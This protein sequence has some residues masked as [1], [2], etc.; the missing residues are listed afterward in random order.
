MKSPIDFLPKNSVFSQMVGIS[1]AIVFV[2]GAYKTVKD[3]L[4][5]NNDRAIKRIE[6]KEQNLEYLDSKINALS[7]RVIN[8]E[9]SNSYL[10]VRINELEN[11]K[12]YRVTPGLINGIREGVLAGIPEER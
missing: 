10:V 2:V 5:D 1:A 9:L 11:G 4:S 12:V 8:L 3:E 7:Y 6:E